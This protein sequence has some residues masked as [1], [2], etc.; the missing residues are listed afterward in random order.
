VRNLWL[1]VSVG[2]IGGLVML[3][4]CGGHDGQVP[5]GGN[6]PGPVAA[7]FVG[8]EVCGTCHS[9]INLAY[10]A[11]NGVAYVPTN[12]KD[13]THVFTSFVGSAHGQDMFSKGV[14]NTDVLTSASCQPCHVTGYQETSGFT[15]LTATPHLVGIGCEECHG[16]G[17]L[18]AG[19]PATS[20]ITRLPDAETTCW[21][22]HVPSYKLLRSGPP[23]MVTDATLAP[24]KANSVAQHHPQAALLDGVLAY[25]TPQMLSPH[26]EIANNC[27]ACHLNGS[28]NDYHG[29]TALQVD[30]QTCTPCHSSVSSPATLETFIGG[31]E[32][33]IN[34]TL[35]DLM[36]ETSPGSGEPDEANCAGGKLAAYASFH[37]INPASSSTANS[38]DVYVQRYKAARYNAQYAVVGG[39]WHNPPL[40][41]KMLQ[42]AL[43]LLL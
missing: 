21:D 17:S 7:V 27:V 30:Y 3:G 23:A 36:G 38:T 2:V 43:N 37:G 9:D 16:K 8:R 18:H 22:C 29:S 11:Y 34:A 4:G 24:K 25:N 28:T 42:D 26:A 12:V 1:L 39:M 13:L 40:V 31:F 14:S 19:G 20:N 10:G 5:P 33:D 6:G 35:I 15:S 32:D 41:R